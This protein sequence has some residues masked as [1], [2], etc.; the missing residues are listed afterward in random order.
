MSLIGVDGGNSNRTSWFANSL[1]NMQFCSDVGVKKMRAKA[2][3]SLAQVGGTFSADYVEFE[4]K[5]ALEC[6][7][8]DRNDIRRHD[9]V[10][11]TMII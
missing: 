10:R 3:G 4:V 5:K 2:V 1:R 6:I 9:A 11:I 7:D 8:G